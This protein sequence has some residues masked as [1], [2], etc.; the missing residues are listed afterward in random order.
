M[1][2]KRSIVTR[3][4][5]TAT[6]IERR[7]EIVFPN[8]ISELKKILDEL[9]IGYAYKDTKAVLINKILAN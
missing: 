4:I 1:P 3:Y 7:V 6:Q 2:F 8:T 9:G 5:I